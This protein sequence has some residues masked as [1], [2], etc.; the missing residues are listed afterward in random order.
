MLIDTAWKLVGA[1]E[2][3]RK[4]WRRETTNISAWDQVHSMCRRAFST[5][6][7][8]IL[9]AVIVM[10]GSVIALSSKIQVM[11]SCRYWLCQ[12]LWP[13]STPFSSHCYCCKW[14]NRL[15]E[16]VVTDVHVFW[17]FVLTGCCLSHLTHIA[18]IVWHECHGI[19]GSHGNKW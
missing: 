5:Q 3:F 13:I 10:Q 17:C 2:L 1:H 14:D 4:G 16:L 15:Y 19:W 12:V 6:Q 11:A 7:L 18:H 8:L 9:L